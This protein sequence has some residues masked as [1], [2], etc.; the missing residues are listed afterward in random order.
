M[1]GSPL[2]RARRALA[3]AQ[4]QEPIPEIAPKDFDAL[5]S[6][7]VRTLCAVSQRGGDSSQVLAARA[8]LEHVHRCETAGVTRPGRRYRFDSALHGQGGEPFDPLGDLERQ[9]PTGVTQK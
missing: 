2:K 3:M 7:A 1:S 5:R 6:L 8:L 4:H 9:K